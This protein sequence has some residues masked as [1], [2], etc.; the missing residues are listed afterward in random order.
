MDGAKRKEVIVVASKDWTHRFFLVHADEAGGGTLPPG[1]SVLEVED[2]REVGALDLGPIAP[3]EAGAEDA[4]L[5]LAGFMHGAPALTHR[6]P[7]LEKA[8]PAEALPPALW[9]EGYD[10]AMLLF[11]RRVDY[12][13]A[14]LARD[15]PAA[16]EEATIPTG[17]EGARL[18]LR[19]LG[20]WHGLVKEMDPSLRSQVAALLKAAGDP[21]A[22]FFSPRPGRPRP[23]SFSEKAPRR[24]GRDDRLTHPA[25]RQVDPAELDR[26]LQPEGCLQAH[27]GGFEVRPEQQAMAREVLEAFNLDSFLVVEAGTGVGKSM[28]YLLPAALFSLANEERVVVSTHTKNLQDQLCGRDLPRLA[29][30]IPQLRYSRLKGRSNYLCL[31]RWDEWC[32]YQFT[33]ARGEG[34]L[35]FGGTSPLRAWAAILIYLHHTREGDLEEL[36][37]EVREQLREFLQAVCSQPE[38]CLGPACPLRERCWVEAARDRAAASHVVVV[39]HALLLSDAAE[40]QALEEGAPRPVLPAYSRLVVDEAHHL[41]RVATEIFSADLSLVAGL[42]FIDRLEAGRGLLQ[43]FEALPYG[44]D[45]SA[46]TLLRGLRDDLG[47]LREK[48]QDFFINRLPG[49]SGESGGKGR[50]AGKGGGRGFP[51]GQETRSRVTWQVTG[52][53]AW[54]ELEK[55]GAALAGCLEAA[56]GKLADLG[57]LAAGLAGEQGIPE[58][59]RKALESRAARQ[60]EACAGHAETVRGFFR[61]EPEGEPPSWLRWWEMAPRWR[62]R[63]G[64][65]SNG[66]ICMAPVEMGPMLSERLL[67]PLESAVFTSATLRA[68]EGEGG[69]AFFSACAGLDRVDREE[70]EVKCVALGSPFDYASQ[71]RCL[72]VTDLPEQPRASADDAPYLEALGG[73]IGDALEASRGR[74]LVLFTSYRVLERV[75]QDLFPVLEER[76]IACLR[77]ERDSSNVQLLGRFREEVGSAL[78][79]TS[80]FWEGVDVPGESL[81][82]VIITKLPFAYFGDPLMEGRMEFIKATGRGDGWREYY[83]PRAVMQFRQG[84]GRLIRRASDH[85]VM[86]V[87]DPR[88]MSRN[89]SSLF[90]GTLPGGLPVRRVSAAEAGRCVGEFLRE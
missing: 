21:L 73:V 4:R 60:A 6:L 12:S 81:S 14:Q 46:F 68:G 65:I 51:A 87:L 78:F 33:D 36:S 2:F 20:H 70:R 82:L 23:L 11:P 45:E 38:E 57:K 90:L 9:L 41:E 1:V 34:R 64:T 89:Y 67:A 24:R 88:V 31:K 50:G 69:F 49:L 13:L 25:G 27:D 22:W 10:L 26:F 79:A 48:L 56:A 61:E 83:L 77:Q 37:L 80:S 54:E 74:G 59:E 63:G 76:G 55:S 52:T 47:E 62:Y 53:P 35:G 85:G 18:Y 71:A 30:A 5:R 75:A 19:L 29:R 72:V 32:G 7:L 8:V 66:R 86:L 43:R 42:A 3:G 40:S 84:L 28:A 15:L 16:E 39:N 17:L 44:L 58:D